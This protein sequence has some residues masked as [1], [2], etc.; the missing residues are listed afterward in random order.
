MTV[1]VFRFLLALLLAAL[2]PAQPAFAQAAPT[3]A[4]TGASEP[5]WPF[6]KSDLPLDPGYRFSVLPNGL[7]VIVRQ[8]SSPASQAVVRLYIGAGSLSETDG[9][10]GY[11]HFV[12]HMAFNGSANVPEGEMVRLLER[13]G[14]AFGADTNASTNFELTLYKLDL[15]RTDPE[16]I[17]TAL[18]LMRETASALTFDP[19]AVNRERGVVMSELRNGRTYALANTEDRFAFLYPGA[20]FVNRLPIGTV[21]SLQ[22][23]TA[24]GLRA[25]WQREYRPGNAALVVIGDFDP[26]AVEAQIRQHFADWQAPGGEEKVDAGPVDVAR[27]GQTDVY[28]DPALA[29]RVTISRNAPWIDEPDTVEK[30]RTGVLRQIGY[31]I[32]N[33]RLQR[34][35]RGA[36]A[37]FRDGGFGTSD[38]FEAGRTTSLIIDA[39]D[40]EWREGMGAAVREYRKAL[41]LGFTQAEIDEQVANLRTGLEN[42]VA[43]A[44]TRFHG[45]FERAVLQMLTDDIVPTTP[46]SGLERFEAMAGDITPAN[47]LAALTT[48]AVPLADPLIRFEGRKAPEGGVEALRA[49][50]TEA[51]AAPVEAG[52]QASLGD[53]GYTDFG[54]PGKVVSD[55]T[56]P[57]LGIRTLR[58]ANGV[59]LNLKHTDLERDRV[60]VEMNIDGGKMLD[61]RA[62]P[63]ATALVSSMVRGG[64]GK[65][66]FDELETILAGRS[67]GMAFD[68]VDETFRAV[69]TTTPRDLE[70]QLQLFA[71]TLTDPGYRPEAEQRYRRDIGNFFAQLNAT[72]N[73]ALSNA[74]GG[75]LSDGDPRF[76]LAKEADYRALTFARLKQDISD[77]LAH[78]AIE[79]ALVGDFDE[80]QAIDFVARTLGALTVREADFRPYADN[81]TRP[82]ATERDRRVVRHTGEANQALLRFT[83]PTRDDADAHESSV[84]ELLERVTRIALT[85]ELRERLGETYSPGVSASQSDVWTDYGT[86][87]IAA[88]VD[89]KDIDAA[90]TAMLA[91]VAALAASPPDADLIDRARRPLLEAYDNALKSNGSWMTLVD[92]AQSRPE[93][94][95]RFVSARQRIEAITAAELQAAA[96]KYLT[97]AAAVEI[98]VLP[99]ANAS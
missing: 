67:V 24:A 16:L 34:I 81:R 99:E 29:E 84:L 33:R 18:M 57:L 65:H 7:R 30:R 55:A 22:G 52:A 87:A 20:R 46:E 27:A 97:P 39:G 12:E 36:D 48:E 10:R 37:P 68:D 72:P 2:V 74:L 64:L 94:I 61:T 17:D 79:I 43:N 25:F 95:R 21:E 41:S 60:R 80:A 70:L 73:A 31:G 77:R 35:A 53:F 4:A 38:V 40:G 50:W 32:I 44:A 98:D 88:G 11:A 15:P 51:V 82:F 13:K 83:W 89:V 63:L 6:E 66:S 86:F 85:D 96:A 71:A 47:V 1:R 8:N 92:R 5:V 62:D 28:V 75:I 26:A 59:R 42:S 76:T 93:D 9:E 49:A 91:T 14:L 58:F 54:V 45:T 56:E 23:A 90:R 3:Q 19:E 78:G 69:A